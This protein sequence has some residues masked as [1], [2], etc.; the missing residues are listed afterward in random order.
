VIGLDSNVLIRFFA[1]DDPTQSPTASAVMRSLSPDEPGWVGIAALLELVWVLSKKSRL[2]R[3]QIV[4]L[5]SNLMTRD[6]IVVDQISLVEKAL[7]RYQIGKADFADCFI[8][9]SSLRA[10][11][12]KTVT[13]DR[14]AARDAG[15]ELLV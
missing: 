2:D 8:A 9:V 12:R 15:M 1:K 6:S 10:G 11:C 14:L 3:S 4:N 13:F 7:E 5:I